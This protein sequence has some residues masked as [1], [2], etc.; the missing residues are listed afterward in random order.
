MKNKKAKCF[1]SDSYTPFSLGLFTT[2]SR[3]FLLVRETELYIKWSSSVFLFCVKSCSICSCQYISKSLGRT[4]ICIWRFIIYTYV[5]L[6]KIKT[7]H[8]LDSNMYKI[9]EAARYSGKTHTRLCQ[10][11]H[12]ILYL[13]PRSQNNY[14]M[15][16][17]LIYWNFSWLQWTDFNLYMLKN[18]RIVWIMF[19]QWKHLIRRN[20]EKS[21]LDLFMTRNVFLNLVDVLNFILIIFLCTVWK[22]KCAKMRWHLAFPFAHVR[23]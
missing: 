6:V 1:R 4:A 10:K 14:Q 2:S 16:H 23:L 18:K 3:T 5:E 17:Y 8:W 20:L 19:S 9:S 21:V 12:H 13:F 11:Q 22:Y 7:K 15:F